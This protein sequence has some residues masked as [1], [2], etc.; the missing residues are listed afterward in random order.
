MPC[1]VTWRLAGSLPVNRV[2]EVWTTEGAKFAAFDRLLDAR[3]TGPQSLIRPDVA[4]AVASIL[5]EGQALGF[6]ELGS[7]VVM[8][9]H[10]HVLLLPLIDLSR[11]VSGI[12]KPAPSRQ[13][14]FS[15][16]P[17]HSGAATTLIAGFGIRPRSRGSSAISRTIRSRPGS[18]ANPRLGPGIPGHA[19]TSRVVLLLHFIR[20]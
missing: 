5:F 2:A 20:K 12:K 14:V 19:A 11:V 17:A 9:N 8:P 6:Y 18:A 1:F 10:V 3:A 13:I 7:L 15:A 16:E 4:K